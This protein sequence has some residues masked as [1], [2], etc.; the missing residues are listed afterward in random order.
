MGNRKRRK[1]TDENEPTNERLLER[2]IIIREVVSS[3]FRCDLD[4]RGWNVVQQ[5]GS[6]GFNATVCTLTTSSLRL[7]FQCTIQLDHS[8]R[9]QIAQ[10]KQARIVICRARERMGGRDGCGLRRRREDNIHCV[11]ATSPGEGEAGIIIASPK[12]RLT[13]VVGL[14]LVGHQGRRISVGGRRKLK[15]WR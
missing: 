9:A 14:W 7:Y 13:R 15:Q 2:S 6:T 3:P 4:F 5:S 12:G 10:D 8:A 11:S 1:T